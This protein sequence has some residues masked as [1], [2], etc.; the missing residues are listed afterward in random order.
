MAGFYPREIIDRVIESVDVVD[1]IST[2]L[3]L[4]K[5][6]ANYVGLCPFHQ[7][8]TPSFSVSP[9]KQIF[10]C[11][12][13]GEGGNAIGFL[14]KYENLPFPDALRVLADRGGVT[15]PATS[16]RPAEDNSV[17]Y[18]INREAGRFYRDMLMRAG[19]ES[20]VKRYIKKRGF[21]DETLKKFGIGF[22]PD[23]WDKCFKYLAGKKFSPKDIVKSGLAKHS[24][25]GSA[26]DTFRNRLV[27][28]IIDDRKRVIAFGGRSL[29]EGEK[30][31]KYINSPE[32]PVYH[33]SRSFFGLNLAAG[34]IRERK[35]ALIV[36]GYTDLISLYQAGIQNV[37]ATSGTAFTQYHCRLLKRFSTNLVMV[38]DGD[39]AGVKAAER[40]TKLAMK[41]GVR[42]N[43]VMLP[44]GKDP[45]DLV[46]EGGKGGFLKLVSEAKPYISYL[47]E[48][49]CRKF[50]IDTPEGKSAAEKEM[51][52]YLSRIEDDIEKASAVRAL[53]GR[54]S[55]PFTRIEDHVARYVDIDKEFRRTKKEPRKQAP[56][57]EKRL[58]RIILDHPDVLEAKLADLRPDDFISPMHRRIFSVLAGEI[59]NGCVKSR[60]LLNRVEEED[61]ASH[62]T[63]LAM[64][65]NLY[66][67]D[68]VEENVHDFL[69]SVRMRQRTKMIED[70]KQAAEKAT[71]E[72]FLDRQK[73]FRNLK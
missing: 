53:S 22:A 32:S 35:E 55:I 19:A 44:S 56:P 57:L 36:E 13:C 69:K 25:E 31:P 11:F 38:F 54:L 49:V 14:M 18:D 20:A 46:Q 66:D 4:R 5:S 16:G 68:C 9:S 72:D 60:E 15:L 23:G 10:H 65:A 12:G 42:P 47:I 48:M 62:L 50:N 33:K 40:A 43:I 58:I 63:E 70:M 73:D 51:V 28:P 64:E 41:E 27:F 39:E 6:G 30:I 1:V 45:D 29:V 21:S 67:E 34:R 61:M 52:P 26:R 59:R 17:Y 3:Q 7:E 2:Y 37:V 71:R 24:P 8:K